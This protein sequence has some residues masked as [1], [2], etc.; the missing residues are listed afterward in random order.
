MSHLGMAVDR[1]WTP[2]AD[3]STPLM[4]LD[5]Q[6]LSSNITFMADWARAHGVLLAPH[7]KTTMAPKLW[8]RQLDAGAWAITVANAHQLQVALDHGI[9]PVVVGNTLLDAPALRSAQGHEVLSWVD[10]VAGV[11]VMDQALSADGPAWDVLVELGWPGA[12]TGARTIAEA[13]TV[14]REIAASP[15]LRLRGV[16]GYEGA[17]AHDRSPES[18]AV[19]RAYLRA[20]RALLTE[21]LDA[22]L[23][24]EA[25]PVI[26]AGGSLY[27]DLVAD[28]LGE[29]AA[30]GVAVVVRSGS[31]ITHD[32]GVYALNSPF[33][34]RLVS[35]MHV[36]ARVLSRPEPTLALLDAG[37]RDV[38][39]DSG[40]PMPQFASPSLGGPGREIV[41]AEVFALNDQHAFVRLDA[42]DPLAVGEYVRLGLSHPCTVFDKWR[43][44]PLLRDGVV[45]DEIETCF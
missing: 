34:D 13:M 39:F 23:L 5:D 19:V 18:L 3:R 37:R 43:T 16:G 22:G 2:L 15:R 9:E 4:V 6:A 41:G 20:M 42:A 27:P 26:T 36:W 29:L 30:Q 33:A 14:A 7:G 28:E 45:V 1:T 25:Q 10:S 12:R 11:Q 21:L 44:I 31:Y 40:F 17:L 24:A 8:R 32:D 38:S 35:A